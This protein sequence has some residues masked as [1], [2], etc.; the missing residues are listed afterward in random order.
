MTAPSFLASEV[1]RVTSIAGG[2]QIEQAQPGPPGPNGTAITRRDAVL[3]RP[4]GQGTARS[5]IRINRGNLQ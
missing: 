3:T 5:R 2:G 4:A 1:D